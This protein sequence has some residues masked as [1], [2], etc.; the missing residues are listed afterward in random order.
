MRKSTQKSCGNG[1]AAI[2]SNQSSGLL[3]QGNLLGTD[4]TGTRAIPNDRGMD[5]DGGDGITDQAPNKG[6]RA[7]RRERKVAAGL[8][9]PANHSGHPG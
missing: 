4:I 3:I 6:S 7:V 5:T 1:F 8:M 2:S 9:G